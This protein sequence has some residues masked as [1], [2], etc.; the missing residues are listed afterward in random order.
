MR[1]TLLHSADP[2]NT[3]TTNPDAVH[4]GRGYSERR[5]ATTYLGKVPTSASFGQYRTPFPK[6]PWHAWVGR[7]KFQNG[8]S[9]VGA[10]SIMGG[11]MRIVG[12]SISVSMVD[13]TYRMAVGDEY[14]PEVVDE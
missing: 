7:Q 4:E 14:R 11:F 12:V 8:N 5:T 13:A 9:R 10:Y 2:D 3:D 6:L 1:V